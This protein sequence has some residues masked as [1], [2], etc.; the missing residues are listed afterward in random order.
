MDSQNTR[1]MVLRGIAMLRD[2]RDV[3]HRKI[4]RIRAQIRAGNYQNSL[5]LSIAIERLL[6]ALWDE[7]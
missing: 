5:K 7:N 3:R 6:S 4:R 2:A 1:L